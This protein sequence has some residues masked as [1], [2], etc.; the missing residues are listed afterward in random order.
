MTGVI[1]SP[2]ACSSNLTPG[3]LS[4]DYV[5]TSLFLEGK[6]N[7]GITL[8]GLLVHQ[9]QCF[10]DW[11]LC[12]WCRLLFLQT[13]C[14]A[15][16]LPCPRQVPSLQCTCARV[17][18]ACVLLPPVT[19]VQSHQIWIQCIKRFPRRW[20]NSID[21]PLMHC[22]NHPGSSGIDNEYCVGWRNS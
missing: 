12:S 6:S 17:F 15:L 13:L 16:R 19:T 2:A 3:F 11:L 8:F 10:Y 1:W 7:T 20:P 9:P 22:R 18:P 14:S 5:D 4:G 21:R